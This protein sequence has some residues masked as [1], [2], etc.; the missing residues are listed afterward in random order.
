MADNRNLPYVP[1]GALNHYDDA[2]AAFAR[3]DRDSI[4]STASRNGR[5]PLSNASND[6]SKYAA[7][8]SPSSF[9]ALHCGRLV[10]TI[11]GIEAVAGFLRNARNT[12]G[13]GSLGIIMSSTTRS[14]VFSTARRQPSS[15]SLAVMTSWPAF[16]SARS[17][18]MR[19]SRLSSTIKN[20]IRDH[21]QTRKIGQIVQSVSAGADCQRKA[22]LDCES[23]LPTVCTNKSAFLSN[24]SPAFSKYEVAPSS[25]NFRSLDWETANHHDRDLCRFGT[26]AQR[27]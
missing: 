9:S 8:P 2:A 6:F 14:G 10:R 25:I 19:S 1:G 12:S 11:T 7:A 27:S 26:I 18:A 5:D 22:A 20:F 16:T 24:I 4:P 23:T 15:P 13:P 17:F 3:A 21:P